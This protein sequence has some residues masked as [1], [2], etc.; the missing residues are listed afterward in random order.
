M[1]NRADAS[2]TRSPGMGTSVTLLTGDHYPCAQRTNSRQLDW[3][4]YHTMGADYTAL[5]ALPSMWSSHDLRSGCA[6]AIGPSRPNSDSRPVWPVSLSVVILCYQQDTEYALLIGTLILVAIG[7]RGS[8][9]A[10]GD[11]R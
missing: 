8:E 1:R 5:T 2:S 10:R 4:F 7:T 6:V 3:L 9:T 11:K